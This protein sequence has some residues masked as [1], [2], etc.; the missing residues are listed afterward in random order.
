MEYDFDSGAH[1]VHA[2]HYHLI[3]VTKYRQNTFTPERS[4]FMRRVV[5]GFA[6][7]YGVEIKNFEGDRDHVHMLFKAKPTTDLVRFVNTLKGSSARRIKNGFHLDRELWGDSCWTDSYCLL[8][9]GEV[10]LDALRQ[11][12]EDQRG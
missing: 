7:N 11:Y 9:T 12:V 10:S 2:L 1:S 5:E 8:S 4:D 3:L 6:E